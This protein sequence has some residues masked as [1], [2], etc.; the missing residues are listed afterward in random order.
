[1]TSADLPGMAL[2]LSLARLRLL[3]SV[4][5]GGALSLLLT[6]DFLA[7]RDAG[8]PAALRRDV[9][10]LDRHWEAGDVDASADRLAAWV[11][12]ARSEPRRWALGL[13]RVEARAMA[14][15]VDPDA[16]ALGWVVNFPLPL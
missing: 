1:M 3:P 15:E 5:A 13:D 14:S 8:W 12:L 2:R 7:E 6:L 9:K 11:A 16:P 10:L 4:L